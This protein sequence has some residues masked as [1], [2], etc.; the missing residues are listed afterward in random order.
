MQRLR[1]RRAEEAALR[2]ILRSQESAGDF[3]CAR[4]A[5]PAALSH[6]EN[7]LRSP[8]AG[9]HDVRR[10]SEKYAAAVFFGH[11]PERARPWL[12][13]ALASY[14][15][16]GISAEHAGGM[17]MVLLRLARQCWLDAET[18]RA[19]PLIAE[20]IEIAS[21]FADDT[22][23]ARARLAL[24][25][26]FIIL[27]RYEEAE[28]SYERF[29]RGP[30]SDAPE[31]RSIAYAQQA[32]LRAVRGDR[33]RAFRSFEAAVEA[34]KL[35]PDGYQVTSVWDDF[36]EWA[37]A[38]GDV[39]T[40]QLCRERALFVARERHIVWRVPYLSLRYA[41]ILLEL[42]EYERARE[43]VLDALTYDCATPCI[44]ILVSTVG[45]RLASALGDA[46]LLAR[47][48]DDRALEHA[49]RSSQSGRIGGIASAEIRCALAEGKRDRAAAVLD[50]ALAAVAHADRAWDVLVDAAAVGDD[51]ACE[52]ARALL[53]E[54][55]ALPNG[56]LATA[57]LALFDA[58]LHARRGDQDRARTCASAAAAGFRK[59][60]WLAHERFARAQSP[61][62]DE[63]PA[64]QRQ[65][66]FRTMLGDRSVLSHREAEV[67]DLA[68]KG[69]TNRAIARD[70]SIS[71]HTVESH[72]TS[73]MNRLGIRSRH[74]LSNMVVEQPD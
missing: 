36:G 2:T 4:S 34:A 61:E 55:A 3:A 60:G 6:F 56:E 15:K 10:L 16:A 17:V 33:D 37:L 71:E 13:A 5:Y 65:R 74:Q 62:V 54:R 63:R 70:L 43:L 28:A 41:S 72:M 12:E 40:G 11:Q 14:R 67:A 58:G 39:T 1:Q 23:V 18:P 24:A 46:G 45:V 38:L 42:E 73:I 50:R 26:Y 59:L 25:H 9:A 52:R 19:L 57:F 27:G 44:G 21:A 22:L 68:L 51:A 20:A 49:M 69:L 53:A 66:A 29:R 35:L 30:P 48:R 7:A 8:A 64:T 31:T 47:C 32:I